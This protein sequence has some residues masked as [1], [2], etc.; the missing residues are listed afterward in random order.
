MSRATIKINTDC[1]PGT[2]LRKVTVTGHTGPAVFALSLIQ[3]YLRSK[4]VS[5]FD[6]QNHI[7]RAITR[8]FAVFRP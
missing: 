5:L 7:G 2:E 4:A 8:F 1:E 3:Q 6:G